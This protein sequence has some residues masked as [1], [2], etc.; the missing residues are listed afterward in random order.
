MNIAT[1]KEMYT[2]HGALYTAKALAKQAHAGQV[3]KQGRDYYIAHLVPIAASLAH[4]GE[5]AEI[6][7]WLHDIV[8]DTTITLQD[9]ET[10]GFNINI[11]GAVDAVTRRDET[12]KQLIERAAAHKLGN[13][14]KLADNAWNLLCGVQY[15]KINPKQARSMRKNRYEPAKE[16][17]LASSTITQEQYIVIQQVQK[18]HLAQL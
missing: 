16:K 12:Y 1:Y 10:I 14:V 3:D 8:E 15:E 5:E 6:A 11:T 9:L 4:L 7:G 13:L 2:T 17:L 18:T